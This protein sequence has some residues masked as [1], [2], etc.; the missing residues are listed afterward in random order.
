MV[1][2]ASQILNVVYPHLGSGYPADQ[3]WRGLEQG[4]PGQVKGTLNWLRSDVRH[5]AAGL[6]DRANQAGCDHW[7]TCHLFGVVRINR[8]KSS[9]VVAI[10]KPALLQPASAYQV[11]GVVENAGDLIKLGEPRADLVAEPELL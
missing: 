10:C 8:P 9:R 6:D 5:T 4:M 1:V 2:P 7:V 11:G 3:L